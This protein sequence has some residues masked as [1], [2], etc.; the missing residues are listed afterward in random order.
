MKLINGSHEYLIA[1]STYTK[2]FMHIAKLIE[3]LTE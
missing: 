2:P 3:P 1:E